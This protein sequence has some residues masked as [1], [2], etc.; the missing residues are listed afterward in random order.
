MPGRLLLQDGEEGIVL[1]DKDLCIGCGY[2]FYA[3]PFGAPQYP[4][5]GAFGVRGKMDKCTFCAGGP[6][7]DL[8]KEE[9]AKYGANRL[10][11]GKL[12]ACAKCARQ[13]AA[14]RRRRRDRDIYRQRVMA[15]AKGSEVGAGQR[16]WQTLKSH[17][18]RG[19]PAFEITDERWQLNPPRSSPP[20]R[21]LSRA[22]S[23]EGDG[24]GF[25]PLNTGVP[26][27]H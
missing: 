17:R 23:R 13:G 15:R 21:D 18:R 9:F 22:C 2:C 4:Q 27:Q 16:L 3:C 26:C 6:E 5:S 14:R 7:K 19:V 25:H 1:H 10:A 11:Q 12:P 24:P 20:L 8:S